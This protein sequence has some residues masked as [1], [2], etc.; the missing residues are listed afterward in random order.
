MGY[1]IPN[2]QPAVKADTG[3]S[4]IFNTRIKQ[5]FKGVWKNTGGMGSSMGGHRSMGRLVIGNDFSGDNFVDVFEGRGRI[6]GGSPS[7]VGSGPRSLKL[8]WFSVSPKA[9]DGFELMGMGFHG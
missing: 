1:I 3:N 8:R 6:T 4:D 9:M 2:C 5:L 7:I